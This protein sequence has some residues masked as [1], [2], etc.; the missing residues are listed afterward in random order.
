MD[1]QH[2]REQIERIEALLRKF[3]QSPDKSARDH[4]AELVQALMDVHAAGL[5]RIV[6]AIAAQGLTGRNVLKK[7]AAD[8]IAGGLLAL[9]GLHPVAV[10][11]RV[12]GA[13]ADLQTTLQNHQA[14]IEIVSLAGGVARLRLIA[15]ANGCHSGGAQLKQLIEDS[16]VGAAPELTGVEIEEVTPEPKPVFVPLRGLEKRSATASVESV[17]VV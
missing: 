13:I 7:L 16:L 2:T 4:A 1:H 6:D 8:E 12:R 14:T 3:E 5:A 10:A 11:D 15:A 17:A 9:Y